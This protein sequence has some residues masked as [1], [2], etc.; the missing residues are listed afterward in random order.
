MVPVTPAILPQITDINDNVSVTS[1]KASE[2]SYSSTTF[3]LSLIHDIK[4]EQLTAIKVLEEKFT[5][6]RLRN[7]RFMWIT[8]K[9]VDGVVNEWL[10]QFEKF[11]KPKGNRSVTI[12]EIWKEYQFGMDG[13]L[14][15]SQL[16]LGWNA[17]WKRDIQGIKTEY[18]RRMKIVNLIQGLTDPKAKLL[19]HADAALH[20]LIQTYPIPTSA[21]SHLK[22]T[23]TFIEWLQKEVSP[24][25][26][27]EGVFKSPQEM[28]VDDAR[29]FILLNGFH[30]N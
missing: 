8:R 23:R 29:A 2:T 7:H 12:E 1:Q 9:S 13:H 25:P 30:R 18:S 15:I 19:R 21:T 4:Q 3:P 27:S 26:N 6:E 16:N 5:A 10:P 20:F 14:S 28:I 17:R 11:W 22:T 24:F